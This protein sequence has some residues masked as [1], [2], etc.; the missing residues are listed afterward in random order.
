MK[1]DRF[2][3]ILHSKLQDPEAGYAVPSWN[4]MERRLVLS[5]NAAG[6]V[7]K[8]S[9]GRSVKILHCCRYSPFNRIRRL[10][11][12]PAQRGDGCF[13]AG[14]HGIERRFAAGLGTGYESGYDCQHGTFERSRSR[15]TV[16]LGAERYP[17]SADSKCAESP[18]SGNGFGGVECPAG[19][20]CMAGTDRF[21]S[22]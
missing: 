14:G 22:R 2:D 10:S 11:I 1:R 4:E 8:R 3:D 20:V 9:L 21:V 15:K 16:P 6:V 5:E 13:S 7:R 12:R 18:S 19:A 17:G